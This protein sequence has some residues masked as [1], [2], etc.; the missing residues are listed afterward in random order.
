MKKSEVPQH[1]VKTFQGRYKPVYALGEDGKYEMVPSNGW[2][3]EEIVLDQAVEEFQR[4]AREAHARAKAG[5]G[6][7]LEYHMYA[8]RMDAVLLADISGLWLWRVK[9][10][11]RPGAF[12]ALA[13]ALQ[14]RYADALGLPVPI[15]LALP[16]AP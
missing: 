10:H 3:A 16:E 5:A 1:R 2:E 13:P 4:L 12:A 14:A 8:R 7:A 15:L 11:L 6:S 9:R